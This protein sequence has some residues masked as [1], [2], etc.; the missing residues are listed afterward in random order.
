MKT[1]FFALFLAFSFPAF[2]GDEVYSQGTGNYQKDKDG[3]SREIVRVKV[4]I[5]GETTDLGGA[6][7]GGPRESELH[8]EGQKKIDD[9]NNTN[10]AK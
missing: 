10:D 6:F 2:A 7:S 5:G 4:R 3:S 8:E 1:L 9:A